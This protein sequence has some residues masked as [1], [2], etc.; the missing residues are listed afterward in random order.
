MG[1]WKSNYYIEN[2]YND[3]WIK[4]FKKNQQ[5]VNKNIQAANK[6]QSKAI[7]SA[8]NKNK[9]QQAA[10]GG[11]DKDI[12]AAEKALKTK[13]GTKAFDEYKDK[14]KKQYGKLEDQ[15]S[16]LETKETKIGDVTGLDD[17]LTDLTGK[18]DD[19]SAEIDALQ[20]LQEQLKAADVEQGKTTADIQKALKAAEGDLSAL[21]SDFAGLESDLGDLETTLKADYESQIS[22]LSD[23]F[24]VD[25]EE[26]YAKFDEEKQAFEDYQTQAAQDLTDV[27]TALQTQFGEGY[28]EL[29]SGL[30]DLKLATD[31]QFLDVYKTGEEAIADLDEKFAGQLQ[32]TSASLQEKIA[33]SEAATE[34]KLGQV[35][36][37]Q[38]YRMIGDSAGGIKMR[39]SKAYK[40]GAVNMGTGQLSRSMKLQTLNL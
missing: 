19:S 10:I 6:A 16:A 34:T 3:Q 9:K 38:N 40:S 36:A 24:D 5:N 31:Q 18:F 28:D 23:T 39:R 22:D 29:T 17:Y 37:L 8:Q 35:A 11:L 25:L 21:T 12:K 13:V 27:Q 14:Q 33:E 2:P 4:N 30:E 32:D 20:D 26:V 1:L 15:L 7:K